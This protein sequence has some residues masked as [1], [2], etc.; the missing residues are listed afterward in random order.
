MG[1]EPT[2][3]AGTFAELSQLKESHMYG[4][5]FESVNKYKF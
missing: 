5:N 4:F 2:H 1:N 3:L